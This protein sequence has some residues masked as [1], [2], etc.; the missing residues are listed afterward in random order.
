MLLCL[1]GEETQ[2]EADRQ[3]MDLTEISMAEAQARV[4]IL[5]PRGAAR[6]LQHHR[7]RY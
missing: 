1:R 3:H 4:P 6:R 2:F 5:N 7:A